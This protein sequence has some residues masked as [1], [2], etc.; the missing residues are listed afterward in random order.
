[1]TEIVDLGA[2]TSTKGGAAAGMFTAVPTGE[3]IG[4]LTVGLNVYNDAKQDIGKIKDVA[5]QGSTVKAYIV[6]VGGF[7]GLG[8]HYVAVSPSSMHIT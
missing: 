4:S 3:R 2:V 7:L 6:E 1:M 5:Y 8:D